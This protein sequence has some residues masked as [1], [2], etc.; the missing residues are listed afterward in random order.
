MSD[1]TTTTVIDAPLAQVYDAVLD[2]RSWWNSSIAERPKGVGDEFGF[3]VA[4]LHSTRMR[5]TDTEPGRRVE[6]LVVDN[7]FGFV[8]DPTEWI[9][10]R[11]S[12]DLEPQGSATKLTFTQHGLVAELECYDVCSKAWTFFVG[13]SLRSLVET[14]RGA[15]ETAEADT[16]EV[17]RD[18]FFD[19]TPRPI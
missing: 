4:D 10:H 8:D 12:F 11:L 6:W 18:E 14:G 16:D 2:P 15:P 7:V 17:P 3:E 9:G 5:I 1:F 13:E 19:R